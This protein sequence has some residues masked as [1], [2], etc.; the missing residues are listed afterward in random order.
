VE[1]E[2]PSGADPMHGDDHTLVF[3]GVR[4]RAR[5]EDAVFNLEIPSGAIVMAAASHHGVQ[6][7]F[8]NLLKMHELPKSGFATMGG[9]DLM[10]IE[11][12]NLRKNIHVLDRPTFVGMTIREYLSL[13]CP[14]S[15]TRRMIAALETV[16]LIDTISTFEKGLDTPI[17]STGYPLSSV[18]L[19]QLKLANALL[20]QPRVLVLSRLFD[21]I[22]EEN[23]S[24]AVNELREQAYTTVICFSNRRIDLG[25]D[26]FLYIE[27]KQQ[28]Y[29]AD[30]EDFRLAVNQK[31]PRRPGGR[32]LLKA[33]GAGGK[34]NPRANPRANVVGE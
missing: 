1:Q 23:L 11:A 17:A 22:D 2:E 8:T 26:R 25:F 20:E 18:E 12:H 15:A 10:N 19:Q 6:R 7:L 31:P 30:F 13:A 9:I 24:R 34:V 16:G 28:R 21:L 4:G 27:A 3:E 33:E 32:R 14:E 5:N 29:F